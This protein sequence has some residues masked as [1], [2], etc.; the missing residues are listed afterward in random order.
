MAGAGVSKAA[1]RRYHSG[2]TNLALSWRA[3]GIGALG[4]LGLAC[5]KAGSGDAAPSG[6]YRSVESDQITLELRKN[7]TISLSAQG[8]GTSNGTYR[9]DGEKLILAIDNTERVF[10]RDGDCVE[11][12]EYGKFC[13][14][15]K[16]GEAAN[17]STRSLTSEPGGTWVASNADGTFTL[18]FQTGNRL[19]LSVVPTA[20]A[21]E[22][23]E[24]TFRVEGD[25]IYATLSQSVPLVLK[26]VN[27]AYESTSFGL[28]MR[29]VKRN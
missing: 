13:K 26:F 28:L 4:F 10:I 7:G 3:L 14:G 9:V 25:M 5:G 27:N 29:F 24:G 15:G 17:Q 22:T 21:P 23:S 19:S 16:A 6:T 20:G 11:N 12:R 2:M 8:V 1:Q 18:E